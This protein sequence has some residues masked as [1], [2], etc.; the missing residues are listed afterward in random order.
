MQAG[1]DVVR[2][3]AHDQF[4]AARVSMNAT[5]DEHL[6]EF[7]GLWRWAEKK[8]LVSLTE[9]E[10]QVLEGY[11]SLTKRELHR[12]II[13]FARNAAAQSIP[14]FPISIQNVAERLGVSF[15]HVSKLR[16]EFELAGVIVETAPAVP[17]VSSARYR[18]RQDNLDWE[19]GS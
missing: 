4:L 12:I 14:D 9:H 11:T 17:N 19:A 6:A 10:R 18:M 2:Q 16:K 13:N 8:W 3:N 5:L 15:Q 7:E 1:H